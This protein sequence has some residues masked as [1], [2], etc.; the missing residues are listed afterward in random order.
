[1]GYM[2]PL[3]ERRAHYARDDSPEQTLCGALPLDLPGA[4]PLL[5]TRDPNYVACPDCRGDINEA[6]ENY[7]KE[8]EDKNHGN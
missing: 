1:M 2:T 5:I 6:L 4:R 3:D 7:N 8:H